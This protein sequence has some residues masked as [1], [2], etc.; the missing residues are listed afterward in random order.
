MARTHTTSRNIRAFTVELALDVASLVWPVTCIGCARANR[1]LCTPCR[2]A[3]HDSHAPITMIPAHNPHGIWVAGGPYE[4]M[5]RDLIVAF[6]HGRFIFRNELALA[7]APALAEAIDHARTLGEP[8]PPILVPA[9]S[10]RRAVQERGF[11]PVEEVA[12]RALAELRKTRFPHVEL[13]LVRALHATAGR[14]SQHGLRGHER[15]SNASKVR[16]AQRHRR[17][18]RERAVILIDDVM[19]TGA[20]LA[21]AERVLTEAGANVLGTCTIAAVKKLWE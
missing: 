4:G 10:R 8:H 20:T 21:E 13:R 7:F 17:V 14:T 12:R 16:V 9:P 2:R 18:I 15:I 3:F 1:E 5:R 11:R 19:T 6:K